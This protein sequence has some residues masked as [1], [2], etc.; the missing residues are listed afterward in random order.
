M[1]GGPLV[2]VVA[3]ALAGDGEVGPGVDE[4]GG[5]GQHLV[6]HVLGEGL[7]QPDVVPPLERH[8]IAEPHMGHLVGD[9]DAAGLAFGVGDGGA[10]D[11]LVAEGD[12]AGVLHGAA[13]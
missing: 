4:A 10:V 7:V 6:A 11:E 12:Q 8:Q 9:H 5:L 2:G 13:C 1:G 3:P